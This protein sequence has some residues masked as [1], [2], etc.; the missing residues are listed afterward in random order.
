M[1]WLCTTE[2][3]GLLFCGEAR[4]NVSAYTPTGEK[5]CV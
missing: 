5:V 1:H 3:M 2:L 4:G